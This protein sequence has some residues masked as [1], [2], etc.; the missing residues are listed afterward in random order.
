M[1]IAVVFVFLLLYVV[2]GGVMSEL[3]IPCVLFIVVAFVRVVE[4]VTR[5]I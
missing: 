4:G 5:I 1:C 2:V 3:V